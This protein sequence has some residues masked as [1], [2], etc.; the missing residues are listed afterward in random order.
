MTGCCQIEAI[1]LL[2]AAA[3]TYAQPLT[4]GNA[5]IRD[6]I[7]AQNVH[8]VKHVLDRFVIPIE[9]KRDRPVADRTAM[10]HPWD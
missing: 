1:R 6:V 2:S 7:L 9:K 10:S 3:P 4:G 5:G 8:G